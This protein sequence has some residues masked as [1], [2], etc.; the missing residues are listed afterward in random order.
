MIGNSTTP[1]SG[2]QG[3]WAMLVALVRRYPGRSVAVLGALLVA[4]LLDGLGLSTVL[5]LL[6]LAVDTQSD[7]GAGLVQTAEPSLPEQMVHGV[8]GWFG[9]TPNLYWLLAIGIALILAKAV[10]VLIA[11][12]QVGYAV[13]Q[14][15]TDLRLDLLKA[16]A[17]SHWRYYLA[18]PVGSLT[19]AVA[20]EAQRASEGFLQGALMAAQM[21][22]ALVYLGLAMMISWQV[23]LGSMVLA[24]LILLGLNTLVRKAGRAGRRQTGLLRDL[25]SVMTDQLAA[26]KPLKA[27]GR[28]DRFDTLVTA[29]TASL[30]ESLRKQVVAKEAMKAWQEALLVIVAAVG[31]VF[32]LSVLK[33]P[34][35]EVMVLVFLLARTITLLAKAQRA[36]Q[37]MAISE[38]AFWSLNHAIDEARAA[39]EHNRGSLEPAL[40]QAIH[41]ERVSFAHPG[42]TVF[43]AQDLEIPQRALTVITGPSGAGK[44][45][46]IDLVAGLLKPDAGRIL[47]D[48]I[49]LEQIDHRKWRQMIGYVP[50]EALLVNDTV[51]NNITLG[52]TD[53]GPA[54]VERA[55]RK[56]DA[57]DFVSAL[58]QG[59]H[60]PIGERGGLLSGGQRQRL[61]IA[62]A[63]VHGPALLILDE[64][65]SNLDA[66]AER[67]VLHTIGHLKREL[68][69]LAVTHQPALLQ[70]ADRI[71]RIENGAIRPLSMATGDHPQ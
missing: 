39:R 66:D 52:A 33:L 48:G 67:A 14:V 40:N 64:A 1:Q 7:P 37:Q 53:I 12:K 8:F 46:L 13:A 24:V 18:K 22:T 9:I 41:F 55:L 60:T 11:N 38:S 25:L 2:S 69:I 19:N 51:L 26:I 70:L 10:V 45:T 44:T 17:R 31:L 21:L 42:R 56:A 29:Q 43:D 15:A 4:S 6:S 59:M 23:T 54:E 68:T 3:T 16:V 28:E 62:R 32:M 27:M 30:N 50:Q 20:T 34:V 71:Y 36:W 63:L 35:A 61:A 65:T 49:D 57:W 58:P 47:I 5:S